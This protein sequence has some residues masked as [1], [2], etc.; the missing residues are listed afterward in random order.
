MTTEKE[1]YQPI[2]IKAQSEGTLQHLAETITKSL[3]KVIK[4]QCPD[5]SDKE[6]EKA[7]KKSVLEI[8][9]EFG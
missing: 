9:D 5:V 7:V 8:F 1:L 6:R 3:S 2:L 4:E